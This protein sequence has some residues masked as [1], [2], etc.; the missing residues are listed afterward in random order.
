MEGMVMVARLRCCGLVDDLPE[1]KRFFSEAGDHRD[2]VIIHFEEFE[3]IRL[4][5][6]QGMDQISAA[7]AMGLSRPTFQR[8]LQ[9]AKK[10]LAIALVEG[11]NILIEG[12]NYKMANRTF[13]CQEC[14][15]VWEVPPCTEGGKHGYEIEC[16]KC[17]SLKKIKLE[18][19]VRHVC[20]GGHSQGHTHGGG[21][22]GGHHHHE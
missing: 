13:E 17:K 22:C 14:Q 1:C 16:P 9:S 11:R 2:A 7:E 10:K 5:D 4:K 8:I 20:G 6:Y 12:G 18:N 21:C 19:G 15:H 3:A